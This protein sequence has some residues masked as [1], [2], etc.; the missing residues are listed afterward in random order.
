[1]M[2]NPMLDKA[3]QMM[4]LYL[5][6]MWKPHTRETSVFFKLIYELEA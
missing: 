4:W 6:Y 5:K 1:M 2:N 3:L